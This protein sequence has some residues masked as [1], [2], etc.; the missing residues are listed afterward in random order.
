M[1][2]L[3]VSEQEQQ[4]PQELQL[5]DV[6]KEAFIQA[7]KDVDEFDKE[8]AA[9]K[10]LVD[11]T[12]DDVEVIQNFIG[13]DAKWTFMESLGIGEVLKELKNS[14]DKSGKVFI[15]AVAVEA[16]YYYLSKVEGTGHK[17][18]ASSI[19]T[20]EVYLRLLKAIN[21]ARTSVAN[22]N[23][24][25]KHLEYILACRAEGLDPEDPEL[26]D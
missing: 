23:E 14:V 26:K 1:E 22:D 17:V 20:V 9:K 8:L 16:I 25:K 12:K 15:P 2:E 3:K 18:N 19:G 6:Q 11:L 5:T 24:K 21:A 7:Q 10:Y 4:Q 13:N